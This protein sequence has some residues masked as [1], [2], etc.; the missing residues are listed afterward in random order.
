M[1]AQPQTFDLFADMDAQRLAME[2][3]HRE[4]TIQKAILQIRSKYGK[5]ALLKG[6]NFEEDAMT[7]ERNTQIG[8]HR[9]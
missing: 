1:Q 8:G 6:S 3:E 2:Q 4:R 9:A 5:N 7:R